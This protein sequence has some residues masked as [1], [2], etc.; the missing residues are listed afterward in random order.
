MILKRFS[1][2]KFLIIGEGFIED[3]LK[4]LSTQ[5]AVRDKFNF[6]GHISY[7]N[8]PLYINASDICVS[9]FIKNRN[10]KIGLSPLKLCEYLACAKPVVS[11]NI[12]GIR[13]LLA[14]SNGGLLV[15]PENP[16]KLAN[17]ILKLVENDLLRESMGLS[18][19]SYVLEHRSWLA[20]AR[21][22]ALVCSLLLEENRNKD[23]RVPRDS[24]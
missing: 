2:V 12:S 10:E 16:K 3:S 18:G 13:E 7:K 9:P 6:M 5:L 22:V 15:E 21:K 11:S 19:R 14:D 17:S 1:N 20:G 4:Q 8:V 24:R 23:S